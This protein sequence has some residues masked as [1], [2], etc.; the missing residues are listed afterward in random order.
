M[1]KDA[2]R[3]ARGERL[4]AIRNGLELTREE[5]SK[6]FGFKLMSVRNWE[7]CYNGGLKEKRV[8]DIVTVLTSH[9]I[10]CSNE[11]LLS[12]NGLP[13]TVVNHLKSETT[14]FQSPELLQLADSSTET[15]RINNE[16]S[17]FNE[18]YASQTIAMK[19]E[20]DG[21]L[22][23]FEI[24]QIVAGVRLIGKEI[25]NLIGEPCI[26]VLE[27]NKMLLRTLRKGKNRSSFTLT[28]L[29]PNTALETPTLYDIVPS[30]VAAVIW[31]RRQY[32]ALF[33]KNK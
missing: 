13:P 2:K 7:T 27:E 23:K 16:L 26:V 6:K 12:G 24:G 17:C 11:W 15:S 4:L 19:V 1:E 30:A 9:G 5:F 14:K 32:P 28:C 20:D 22:P 25:Y 3:V 21:M 8:K 33:K 10:E 31:T 29:N 18:G